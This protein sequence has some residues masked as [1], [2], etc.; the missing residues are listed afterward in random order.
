MRRKR[1][2][3]EMH[4]VRSGGVQ[5]GRGGVVKW[6]APPSQITLWLTCDRMGRPRLSPKSTVASIGEHIPSDATQHLSGCRTDWQSP[7][8]AVR[9]SKTARISRWSEREDEIVRQMVAQHGAM[10]SA[11]H[12]AAQALGW[13]RSVRQCRERWVGHLNPVLTWGSWTTDEIERL[14]RL[15]VEHNGCVSKIAHEMK[16]GRTSVRR[17]CEMIDIRDLFGYVLEGGD[18]KHPS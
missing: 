5:F 18:L 4:T 6:R 10:V 1:C 9:V 12:A 11:W 14:P 2:P 17:R 8:S 16:R 15:I 7:S 13:K 3:R